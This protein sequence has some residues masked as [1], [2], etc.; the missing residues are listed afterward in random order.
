M[1]GFSLLEAIFYSWN[2]NIRS[3]LVGVFTEIV[4]GFT[5]RISTLRMKAE[6]FLSFKGPT[7]ACKTEGAR[8]VLCPIR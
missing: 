4:F 7:N 1:D 8:S 2:R 3:L 5:L 6:G